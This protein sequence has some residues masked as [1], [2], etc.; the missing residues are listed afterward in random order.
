METEACKRFQGIVKSNAIFLFPDA[1]DEM[2][3]E[4]SA[5]INYLFYKACKGT[6][7]GLQQVYC[8]AVV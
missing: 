1:N 8:A 7:D 6:G 3:K 5:S 2:Q 4:W